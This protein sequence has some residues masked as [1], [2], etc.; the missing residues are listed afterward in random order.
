MVRTLPAPEVLR[1]YFDDG[2]VPRLPAMCLRWDTEAMGGER[3]WELPEGVTLVGPPPERF[4]VSI[5]R[6]GDDS[7]NVRLLWDRTCLTWE[8]L[9]RAQLLDSALAPLLGAM[10][11]DLWYL[12]DQPVRPGPAPRDRAA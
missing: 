8:D 3:R 9:P 6:R 1:C 7:Y 4:G 11:T 5:R 12:L 10:G 2:F